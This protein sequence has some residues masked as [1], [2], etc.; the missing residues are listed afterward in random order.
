M[1]TDRQNANGLKVT[2]DTQRQ[3]EPRAH[4]DLGTCR[5]AVAQ[6][7][8]S[9]TK[10]VEVGTLDRVVFVCVAAMVVGIFACLTYIA[11]VFVR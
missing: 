10:Q 11:A 2:H 4:T 1:A 7:Y 3:W 6:Q 8:R 9:A 5:C